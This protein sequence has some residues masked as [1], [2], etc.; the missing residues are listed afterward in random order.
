MERYIFNG[1]IYSVIATIETN[2]DRGLNVNLVPFRTISAYIRDMQY[3]ISLINILGNIIPFI[4]MGFIIPMAFPF[5]R[6]LIKTMSTCLLLIFSIE[7]FQLLFYLGSFDIDDF[8]LNLFS[9]FI[10]FMLFISRKKVIMKMV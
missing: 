3:G 1:N 4:P 10:G 7:S 9:C 8:I 6:N 5:Q 2:K